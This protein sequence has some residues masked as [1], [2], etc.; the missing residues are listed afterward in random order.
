M[1]PKFRILSLENQLIAITLVL[2]PFSQAQTNATWTGAT[3]TVWN[4]AGNWTGG[5]PDTAAEVALFSTATTNDPASFGTAVTIGGFNLTG[6]EA[7]NLV[8]TNTI[9]LNQFGVD[10]S[11]SFNFNISGGG[12]TTLA[13]A[14]AW[15]IGS[16]GYTTFSK[17]IANGGLLLT[18]EGNGTGTGLID[19]VISGTGG[20]TKSGAGTWT[21]SGAKTYTGTTTVSGGTQT[22]AD[23]A[24]PPFPVQCSECGDGQLGNQ[25][26][27]S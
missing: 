9:A 15:T 25:A 2:A 4:T 6:G 11:S 24:Q 21:L 13:A 8:F 1:K 10:N 5:V 16:T 22:V 19:S 23:A 7:R 27:G 17:A 18:L 14:Q 26:P 3:N 20:L 12:T